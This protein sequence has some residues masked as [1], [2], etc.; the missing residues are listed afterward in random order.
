[1]LGV[2]I[3]G[4]M[5]FFAYGSAA[6]LLLCLVPVKPF[7]ALGLYLLF[8]GL[9]GMVHVAVFARTYLPW[10]WRRWLVRG[11]DAWRAWLRVIRA[12]SPENRQAHPAP[13]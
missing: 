6:G 8:V 12:T 3:I 10:T 9:A 11:R 13:R 1:M 5:R 4:W 2:P 7:L